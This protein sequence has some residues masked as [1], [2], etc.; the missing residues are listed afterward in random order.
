MIV[1]PFK[2]KYTLIPWKGFLV[3]NEKVLAY[4]GVGGI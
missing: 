1:T 3:W 2:G 4:K